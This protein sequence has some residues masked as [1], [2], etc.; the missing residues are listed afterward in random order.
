[1]NYYIKS[2]FYSDL[3]HYKLMF[4]AKESASAQKTSKFFQSI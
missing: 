1:M 4:T 3:N 2:L